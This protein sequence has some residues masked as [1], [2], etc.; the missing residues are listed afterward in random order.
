MPKTVKFRNILLI[1]LTSLLVLIGV[2]WFCYFVIRAPSF[3]KETAVT[4]HDSIIQGISGLGSVAIAVIIFRI[5]SPENRDH[6]LE[7]T[8]LN[9]MSQTMGWS[10]PEWTSSR[11]GG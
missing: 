11:R 8:T 10:Y 4:I 6:S 5:Q 2:T 3:N 9:Y 1:I 7:K